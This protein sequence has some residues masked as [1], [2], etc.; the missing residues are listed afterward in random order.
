MPKDFMTPPPP[1]RSAMK[2]KTSD[3][4]DVLRAPYKNRDRSVRFGLRSNR[5]LTQI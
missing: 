4:L 2:K 5:D 3:D 1:R